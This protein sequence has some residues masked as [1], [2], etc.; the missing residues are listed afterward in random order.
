MLLMIILFGN[1]YNLNIIQD[2]INEIVDL[3]SFIYDNRINNFLLPIN[4]EFNEIDINTFN[5]NGLKYISEIKE[6]LK[7]N[8]I[9]KL[10]VIPPIFKRL[11]SLSTS[12]N[13][14]KYIYNLYNYN[15]LFNQ[16]EYHKKSHLGDYYTILTATSL[17]NYYF[18][19][20]NNF[21]NIYNI[22]NDNKKIL[23]KFYNK[24]IIGLGISI[25]DINNDISHITAIYKCGN[26][27]FYYDNEAIKYSN[28]LSRLKNNQVFIETKL[29]LDIG[30]SDIYFDF[31]KLYSEINK[32]YQESDISG[33]R[34]I[35]QIYIFYIDNFTSEEDYY[36]KIRHNFIYFIRDYDSSRFICNFK[37][38][39]QYIY[40]NL[41]YYNNSFL[42]YSCKYTDT[43]L[44]KQLLSYPDININNQNND[45]E[46]S[47]II[48]C[49]IQNENIIKLLLENKNIN[50]SISNNNDNTPLIVTCKNKNINILKL[51]LPFIKKEDVLFMNQNHETSL[52]LSNGKILKILQKI[53][54]G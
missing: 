23:Y 43:N 45:G 40:N 54:Y 46:T 52:S 17:F 51:L 29:K 47:L 3:Y 16:I 27:Y 4:F 1:H 35:D 7:N 28:P 30:I 48:A 13:S 22:N 32:L 31:K 14:I 20:N 9:N 19:N 12:L 37:S 26:K 21:I 50:I 49:F 36:D 18:F 2:K 33:N 8:I 6:R 42:I 34:Y 41:D 44:I 53:I 10:D 5:K 39:L 11:N 38:R 24:N 25:V 15:N